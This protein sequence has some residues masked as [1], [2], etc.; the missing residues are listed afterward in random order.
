MANASVTLRK[1]GYEY[2][3]QYVSIVYECCGQ[4]VST[5]YECREQCCEQY[6]SSSVSMSRVLCIKCRIDNMVHQI[7]MEQIMQGLR[8]WLKELTGML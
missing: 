8:L 2:R 4:C 1:A 7:S 3:I 5:V 6:V